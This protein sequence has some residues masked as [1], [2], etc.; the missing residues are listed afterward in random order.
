MNNIER[1]SGNVYADLGLARAD[2]L[3]VK[4]RLAQ[5][6]SQSIRHRRWTQAQAAKTLG[7]TQPKLSNLLRGEFR[8][9]SETKLMACL[10]RLGY[11]VE[12]VVRGRHG[13]TKAGRV[14]VRV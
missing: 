2:E 10:A 4:A 11:N 7:L 8:G 3:Q 1:S 9:I 14:E 13:S 12:I 5:K 6:I